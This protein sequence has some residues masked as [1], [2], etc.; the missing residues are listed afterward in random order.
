MARLRISRAALVAGTP[1]PRQMQRTRT[2]RFCAQ[3]ECSIS[4]SS[5]FV[6]A[7]CVY[8]AVLAFGVL[9]QCLASIQKARQA[10]AP[11][12]LMLNRVPPIDS[13]SD[14]GTKPPAL[15]GDIVVKD[16]VFAYP[17]APAFNICRG[18]SLSIKAG[19]LCALSGPSG[20]GK[21]TIIGLIERFYDP[22]SGSILLDGHDITTLNLR[23]L[24]SKIA[25]VGQEPVLF[26]GT[27]YDA[28]AYGVHGE[29]TKAQVE[30]AARIADAYNFI[31]TV[32]ADGWDTEVGQGGCKLSGGQKQRVA[33]ARAMIKE[34][35]L[36][37]LDEATS[38]LDNQAEKAVQSALD[39]IRERKKKTTITVAHRLSTI[40]HADLICVVNKGVIVEKGTW[41]ELLAMQDG[42]FNALAAKQEAAS[43]ADR[44]WMA[45]AEAEASRRAHHES[46]REGLPEAVK[47]PGTLGGAKGLAMLRKVTHL[48]FV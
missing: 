9:P 26:S 32:L 35:E 22:Q 45:E 8:Y 4:V 18:Y 2:D 11:I 43:A 24:R 10:C 15:K 34:P 31:T 40:R 44:Q 14:E 3:D 17:L 36:V 25:L 21:S 47:L 7:L 23:W 16:V 28:I 38:A 19:Q 20:S 13:F 46:I 48:R 33:I 42:I 37:L 1:R 6:S 29:C 39:A 41:E 27:V 30:A 12:K 5:A